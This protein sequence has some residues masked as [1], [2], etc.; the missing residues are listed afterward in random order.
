MT[1][2]ITNTLT[3]KKQD[4]TPLKKRR[5]G[6]YVCGPTVYDVPHIG[7]ARSAYVFDVIRRYLEYRGF[8]V[9]FVR[10]VT[11]VDDKI[12]DKARQ[13][14]AGKDLNAA[15]KEISAKYLGVYHDDM[16]ALGIKSPTKE[17]KATRYI[18]KMQTF[19]KLLINKG[20][21][22]AAGEDVYFDIRKASGYGKLS[23]QS[24][25]NMEAGARV[26]A[27]ENK[28]DPLDHRIRYQFPRY[29]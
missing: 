5:V 8:K 11:D 12:I 27:G 13:E 2:R 24:I 14:T 10:N 16:Q 7:H 6:I 4:F 17:P 28:K 20:V 3:R 22:Y 9:N 1:I 23:N 15:V 25:D 19:I 26:L 21:A 29:R 18:K